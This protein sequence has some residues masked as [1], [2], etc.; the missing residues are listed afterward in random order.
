VFFDDILIYSNIMN[1]HLRH[2]KIVF[3]ILK[4]NKLYAKANKCVFYSNQ[5]E[6]L[7]HIIFVAG[8]WIDPQKIKVI[9]DW[10]IPS[11]I[12][13][14]RG[15]LGLIGYYRRF[16]KG[17]DIICI[18]LT[19]LLNNEIY[20]W[21]EGAIIAFQ[22]LKNIMTNPLVLNYQTWIKNLSWR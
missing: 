6:Y 10:P 22:Q 19:H 17:Y 11:N 7:G 1:E 12:K 4:S 16:V 20:I 21:N 9:L 15:F 3:E 13:Q 14:L 2:L 8:V 5:V 18:P